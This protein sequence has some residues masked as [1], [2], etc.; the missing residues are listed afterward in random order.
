MRFFD[1]APHQKNIEIPALFAFAEND[2]DVYPGWAIG[3]L[4]ETFDHQIPENFSLQIIPGADHDFKLTNDMCESAEIRAQ[5]N[6]SEY[7]QS[8]F[9]SWIL[10]N[11]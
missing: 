1:P 5:S 7:F 6:Y 2:T 11:L 8:V 9:E 4:N 10:S 3:T